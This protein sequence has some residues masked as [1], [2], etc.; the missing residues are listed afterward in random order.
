[1]RDGGY[2]VVGF[3]GTGVMIRDAKYLV[4]GLLTWHALS[5]ALVS[6]MVHI[7]RKWYEHIVGF[8]P[9]SVKNSSCER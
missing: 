8:I 9:F 3:V 2:P 4:L 1:M 7:N 5:G 6:Q